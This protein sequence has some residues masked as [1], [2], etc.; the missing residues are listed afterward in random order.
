MSLADRISVSEW[1]SMRANRKPF[2]F[3]RPSTSL[4]TSVRFLFAHDIHRMPVIDVDGTVTQFITFRTVCRFLVSRFRLPSTVLSQSIISLDLGE[5]HPVSVSPQDPVSEVLRLL[6]H[7][8]LSAVPVVSAR[9]RVVDVFSKADFSFLGL[10]PSFGFLDIT[11]Q[12]ALSRRPEGAEVAHK[13]TPSAPIGTILRHIAQHNVHRVI[14]VAKLPP[15]A[16]GLPEPDIVSVAHQSRTPGALEDP[17]ID[18]H[19]GV[20]SL[21]HILRFLAED[22][23]EGP[24]TEVPTPLSAP[25]L[26]TPGAAMDTPDSV[27]AMDTPD[28]VS[29]ASVMRERQ[30]E[31]R[32][33]PNDS[34]PASP[35]VFSI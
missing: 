16:E 20:V 26:S 15:S 18:K 6:L 31:P 4:H 19:V 32:Q 25:A 28:S 5:L 35:A 7:Y 27:S 12:D 8:H 21:R 13:C 2:L 33:G 10:D 30:F 1:K 17:L 3:A 34:T 23:V 29:A 24:V 9:G 11:V 22:V 14:I